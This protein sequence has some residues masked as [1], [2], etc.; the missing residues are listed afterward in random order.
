M[1]RFVP[2]LWMSIPIVLVIASIS[3][4]TLK[5]MVLM[6]KHG[7]LTALQDRVFEMPAA[8]KDLHGISLKRKIQGQFRKH[9]IHLG[10]DKI[11]LREDFELNAE[12][13]SLP[14]HG[15]QRDSLKAKLLVFIPF[16]VHIPLYGKIT[17][18]ECFSG[19]FRSIGGGSNG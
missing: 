16:S 18:L 5:V 1:R 7:G 11:S 6:A 19:T 15:C 14:S 3:L 9:A 12:K 8:W 10:T 4:P 2:Y 17:R 13:K